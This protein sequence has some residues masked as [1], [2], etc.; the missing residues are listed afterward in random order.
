LT[1]TYQD[2]CII[3]KDKLEQK[4]LKCKIEM[5]MDI[6]RVAMNRA[7]HRE[8]EKSNLE[9]KLSIVNEIKEEQVFQNELNIDIVAMNREN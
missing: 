3:F 2:S 8:E 9:E 6:D 1:V 4:E 5:P 7:M